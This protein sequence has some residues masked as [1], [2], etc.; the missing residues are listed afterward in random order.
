LDTRYLGHHYDF[1]EKLS[2]FAAA[3]PR[4]YLSERNERYYI[5]SVHGSY[6]GRF[7]REI[8]RIYGNDT[9]WG[10]LPATNVTPIGP[11]PPVADPSRDQYEWGVGE[12]ADYISLGPI[13]NPVGTAWAGRG[14]V[15]GYDGLETSRRA[16]IITHSRCSKK[17]LDAMHA[18]NLKGNHVGSEMVP[19]TVAL[20]HGLKAVFAP[21][22]M[23]FDRE[24]KGRSLE[25]WF[26]PGPRGESGGEESPFGWFREA[27]FMGSTWYYR[28]VAPMRLYNNWLGYEDTGIGGENWEE[29]HG[30]PCLPPLLLHPIK[31][32]EPPPPGHSSV[33]K[34]PY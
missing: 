19:Q 15:W 11:T 23:F 1:L 28:A 2:S 32:T 16:T 30:R 26:N 10:P 29:T 7:R 13:F 6:N 27:R 17:L 21:H 5:P 4:K 24:W 14:D 20:H 22:S 34:L 31:H 9:I 33:A 18:E 3:Q 12:E 8:E 25:K